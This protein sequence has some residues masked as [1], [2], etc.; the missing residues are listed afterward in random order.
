MRPPITVKFFSGAVREPSSR[1]R[2]VPIHAQIDAAA[3][4]DDPRLSAE[5]DVAIG[6]R[7]HVAP[8]SQDR[9]A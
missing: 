6:A 8:S 4:Q 5:S 1:Y 2:S 3:H 9:R 7:I